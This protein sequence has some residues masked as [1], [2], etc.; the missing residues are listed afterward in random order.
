[1]KMHLFYLLILVIFLCDGNGVIS[2][3]VRRNYQLT[4]VQRPV[5]SIAYNVKSIANSVK[6][7]ENVL[8]MTTDTQ[9]DKNYELHYSKDSDNKLK[10]LLQSIENSN[11]ISK[12][13]NNDIGFK[14]IGIKLNKEGVIKA[15]SLADKFGGQVQVNLGD[16]AYGASLIPDEDDLKQ[17]PVRY[18]H[19]IDPDGNGIEIIEEPEI[20]TMASLNY[21]LDELNLF[22]KLI[23]NVID[24]EETVVFYEMVLNMILVR[25]RSNV[26]GIPK[27]ASISAYLVDNKD[28][29]NTMIELLYKYSTDKL[30]I[31]NTYQHMAITTADNI[32][33]IKNKIEIYNSVHSKKSGYNRIDVLS[34]S[35]NGLVITDPINGYKIK[36]DEYRS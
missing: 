12:S 16:Y 18:T 24:I 21:K 34:E 14:G 2:T 11:I 36:I 4:M 29:Y 9:N 23:F 25:K 22:N 33:N 28:K 15:V 26:N 13:K 8:G 32:A 31:S 27:S 5:H 20:P 1:M 6:F 7:Y 35:D 19:I 30:D 10:I 3:L 17:F